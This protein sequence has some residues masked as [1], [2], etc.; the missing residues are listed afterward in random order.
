MKTLKQFTE[1]Q[2][3]MQRLAAA[4]ENLAINTLSG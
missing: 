3:I 2:R 1:T 4:I